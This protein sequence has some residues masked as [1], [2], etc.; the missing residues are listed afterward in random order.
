MDVN[1][2]A[3]D[4]P[5]TSEQKITICANRRVVKAVTVGQL[6]DIVKIYAD[7]RLIDRV[8]FQNALEKSTIT[9]NEIKT[10]CN[11]LNMPWQLFL[12]EPTK[13]TDTINSIKNKRKAKFNEK[14]IANRDGNGR[15][16]SLRIA[17][18]VI[19]L[20][21]YAKGNVNIHNSFCGSMKELSQG[22]G[23]GHIINHFDI[24]QDRLH[25]RSKASTLDYL[26][27]KFEAKNIRVARGVLSNKIMPKSPEL[28]AT[29][30]K[31]SG[32]IIHDEKIP[33]IFLPSEVSEQT[34]ATGRQILTLLSLI[35]L[36]GKEEHNIYVNGDLETSY[37]SKQILKEAFEIAGE[38]LLPRSVTD[39]LHS[40][41]I[42]A[43]KRDELAVEYML[44]P[45]ALVVTLRNRNVLESDES[46]REL[47]ESIPM[48]GTGRTI[49]RNPTMDTSVRKFCG[50]TT[51]TEVMRDITHGNL[52]SIPAQ[53][54]LFGHVDK[55]HFAKFKE[56]IVL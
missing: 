2:W 24:D 35:V 55:K 28:A 23:V 39:Q 50:N 47:L 49:A 22:E 29:Y 1:N 13:L 14:L 25:G 30:R 8:F 53:Y 18:R 37:Q 46:M 56:G 4:V 33:Y 32:F 15:G 17:D 12:L 20:Q 26:I 27:K 5:N 38:I 31:S 45:S 52:K 42:D 7:E 44:T 34:E 19:A 54:L 3:A 6:I 11:K 48:H 9:V 21:E 16:I 51:A 10:E 40:E 43:T 36:V 41:V